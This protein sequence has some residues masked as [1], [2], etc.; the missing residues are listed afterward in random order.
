[1]AYASQLPAPE[2]LDIHNA[3][4]AEL[5]CEWVQTWKHYARATGLSEKP[6]A[7]QVSTLLTVIGAPARRVFATFEWNPATNAEKIQPVLDQFDAYC[8]PRRNVP[9]ERYKFYK[10]QQQ[11]GESFDLYVTEL[12]QLANNCSFDDITPDEI[13]RDRILFGIADGRVR[14]ALLRKDD[15]TL[16]KVYK[17]FGRLNCP[18]HRCVN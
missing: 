16:A 17:L 6:E 12:R 3:A 15:L 7:V 5:W 13:L 2:P 8:Q 4:A 1:M 18:T 11:A 14:E 10:R 9:F